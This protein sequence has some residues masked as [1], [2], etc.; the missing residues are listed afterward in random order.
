MKRTTKKNTLFTAPVLLI[1]L[2]VLLV[3]WGCTAGQSETQPE[4]ETDPAAAPAEDGGGELIDPGGET[5][6]D[7]SITDGETLF[8]TYCAKCHGLGGLG[9]G[10]SVGSL[11]TQSGMNLTVLQDRTDEEI[12]NTITGG[13]GVEM[14][15]WGLVL[16]VE[17]RQA[18]V[19]YI[20]TLGE[21]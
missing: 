3:L 14:P 11:S 13:K 17:Q 15:P 10:P 6:F 4:G 5:I 1:L 8:V 7:P 9:D 21:Q 16:T 12:F 19:Q 20:R 18:L 2:G